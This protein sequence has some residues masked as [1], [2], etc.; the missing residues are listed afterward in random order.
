MNRLKITGVIILA[1]WMAYIT[2][3][4]EQI[5]RVADIACTIAYN[6]G[7]ESA[8]HCPITIVPMIIHENSN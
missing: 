7:Q 4:V 1:A 2:W 6:N 8:L 3:R 5:K